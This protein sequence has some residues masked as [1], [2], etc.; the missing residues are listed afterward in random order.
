MKDIKENARITLVN[1][2]K[3]GTETDKIEF[4]SIGNFYEKDGAYHITYKEH[5]DMGM[6]D[7]RVFLRI[8]PERINMRRMGEFRT[9]MD[10][11]LDCVTEFFYR[12]PYGEMNIKIKT[13]KI[14]TKLGKDGG[15]VDFSYVLLMGDSETYNSVHLEVELERN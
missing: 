9:N 5:S 4:N 10:Y 8:E 12:M 6:G 14:D 11:R 7:S 13:E 2:Q 3:N 15:C 1:N